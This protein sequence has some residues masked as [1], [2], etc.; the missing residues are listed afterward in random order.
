MLPSHLFSGRDTSWMIRTFF[1]LILPVPWWASLRLAFLL[2]HAACCCLY[3]MFRHSSCFFTALLPGIQRTFRGLLP[4]TSAWKRRLPAGRRA[5]GMAV[6]TGGRLNS[7]LPA[8]PLAFFF[9]LGLR[10]RRAADASFGGDGTGTCRAATGCACAPGGAAAGS[11]SCWRGR[12]VVWNCLPISGSTFLSLFLG[13]SR[14]GSV[15]H[16]NKGGTGTN[17]AS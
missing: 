9:I 11:P 15:C 17:G 2:K 13:Y 7:G 3:A 14:S 5:C 10:W 12:A 1:S 6:Y 16:A 8:A 4:T